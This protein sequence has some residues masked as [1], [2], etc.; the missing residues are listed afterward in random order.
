MRQERG[1]RRHSFMGDYVLLFTFG[2]SAH[3]GPGV[4]NHAADEET[5]KKILYVTVRVL[6]LRG[7][8]QPALGEGIPQTEYKNPEP[9]PGA[10]AGY[11]RAGYFTPT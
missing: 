9:P 2:C 4:A 8:G 7:H 3:P 10:R 11:A 5:K 1:K 6:A